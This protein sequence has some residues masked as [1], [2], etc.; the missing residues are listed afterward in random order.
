MRLWPSSEK[1]LRQRCYLNRKTASSLCPSGSLT[2]ARCLAPMLPVRSGDL[3]PSA[4]ERTSRSEQ[5]MN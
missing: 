3:Y 5:A 4:L 1:Y 2:Q